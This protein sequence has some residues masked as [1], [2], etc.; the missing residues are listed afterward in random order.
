MHPSMTRQLRRALA[1]AVWVLLIGGLFAMHG[2]GTHGAGAHG[3]VA[4]N[5][6]GTSGH[7]A[8]HSVLPGT[9]DR[10]ADAE[11]VTGASEPN[12]EGHGSMGLLMLCL[13]ILAATLAGFAQVLLRHLR[14]SPLCTLPWGFPAIWVIG[15]DRDPPDLRRLSVMRC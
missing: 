8:H 11:P 7:A 9:A 5:M 2:L 14:R 15:R 1:A 10:T 4:L 6:T 12:D 13:V 3:G